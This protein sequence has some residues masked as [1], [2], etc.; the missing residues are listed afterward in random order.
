MKILLVNPPIPHEIELY[1][2]AGIVAPPMG[3][4]YL[5]AVLEKYG[6]HVEILDAPVLSLSHEQIEEEI[7][8]REPDIVGITATTEGKAPSI[9][10]TTTKTSTPSLTIFLRG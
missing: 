5:A 7:K 4:T 8:K 6:Y 3:L 2:T 9:P 10:A 1:S